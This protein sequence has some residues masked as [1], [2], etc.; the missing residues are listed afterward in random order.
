MTGQA[1]RP[2]RAETGATPCS[3]A[4]PSLVDRTLALRR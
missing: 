3:S 1:G 4:N 2:S